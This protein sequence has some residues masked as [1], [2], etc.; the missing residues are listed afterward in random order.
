MTQDMK[1]HYD[2]II[3]GGGHNGLISACYL[4]KHGLDV[5]LLERMDNLGG[6]S[7]SK[8]VFA[9]VDAQISEYAYLVGPL[10]SKMVSDLDIRFKSIMRK[11]GPVMNFVDGGT[12]KTLLMSNYS[13]AS[14]RESFIQCFGHDREFQS[15]KELAQHEKEF[16]RTVFRTLTE[17]LRSRADMRA[18]TTKSV[19]DAIWNSFVNEPLG[20][21]IESRFETSVVKGMKL[22][23]AICGSF[24]HAHDP[25]LLQNRS[26]IFHELGECEGSGSWGIPVGGW[27][28][29]LSQLIDLGSKHGVTYRPRTEVRAVRPHPERPSVSFET[30]GKQ[31]T[32]TCDHVLFCASPKILDRLVG[33]NSPA[34]D[35]EDLAT[36]V[37]KINLML[38][39]LP[40]LKSGVPPEEAFNGTFRFSQNYENIYDCYQT[41]KAGKAPHRPPGDVYCHSL[42]DDTILSDELKAKGAHS[43]AIFGYQ[44]PYPLFAERPDEMRKTMLERYLD[45]LNEHLEIPIQ[46]C[47]LN[48]ANGEPCIQIKSPIDVEKELNIPQGQIYHTPLSWPFAEQES[49]VGTWGV[50]TQYDRVVIGGSGASRGGCVSGIPGHNAAACILGT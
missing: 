31:F 27:K 32:V 44:C 43:M 20:K 35:N 28:T 8:A 26:M 38:S 45:G 24:T 36:S 23:G 47:I 41:T 49:E 25:T 15:F 30:D 6:A 2:A 16:G 4:A 39:K 42:A 12:H 14:S 21:L 10:S 29:M 5:L 3:V 22:V 46:E 17:P 9:G 7:I 40:P 48:D 11:Y 18:L 50:E 33:E 34:D 19:P 1:S 13:E 37:F